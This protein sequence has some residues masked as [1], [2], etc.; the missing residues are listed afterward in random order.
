MRGKWSARSTED[1]CGVCSDVDSVPVRRGEDDA[2]PKELGASA[3]RSQMRWF[4]HLVRV[5]PGRIPG[6]VFR[7]RPTGRRPRGR[8]KTHWRDYVSRLALERFR[9][10]LE[11]LDEVA[12]EREV[13]DFL[14]KLLP[15]RPDPR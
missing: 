10:P 5:P 4:G 6:E 1:R 9:T 3:L 13:W 12:G 7:A 2:E 8:P 15:P 11:E 14:L